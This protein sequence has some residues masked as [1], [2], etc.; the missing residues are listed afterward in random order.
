MNEPA[1]ESN[2][3]N[4]QVSIDDDAWLDYS[5]LAITKMEPMD[6]ASLEL[7]E[8]NLPITLDPDRER[9]IE[10]SS[11]QINDYVS[12]PQSGTSSSLPSNPAPSSFHNETHAM[13]N[14]QNS[15]RTETFDHHIATK[16]AEMSSNQSITGSKLPA[17]KALPP[18]SSKALDHISRPQ[19]ECYTVSSPCFSKKQPTSNIIEPDKYFLAPSSPLSPS[20]HPS[21]KQPWSAPPPLQIPDAKLFNSKDPVPSPMPRSIPIPPLSLSTYLQLELS[22]HKPSPLYIHRSRMSDVPY[23]SSSVKMERLQNFL[24]LP[25]QLEQVLWF[26]AIACLDAWLFTFTI[27]PLRFLKALLI[28]SHSWGRNAANE[29]HLVAEYIYAGAGRMWK[30]QRRRSA[31]ERSAYNLSTKI[32]PRLIVPARNELPLPTLQMPSSAQRENASPAHSHP[33]QDGK[34]RSSNAHKHRKSKSM[35]STLLPDHKADI[36]KGFL[37]IISCM[38]LMHFDASRM[39]HNIRGQAAIKLYVIYNVLEVNICIPL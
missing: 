20:S 39:Y 33:Q 25:P 36:I 21:P 29:V 30:R 22:S 13:W 19:S 3:I 27:L 38:I 34:R 15:S 4:G 2:E 32:D 18:L 11:S 37:I 16:N 7:R 26:G 6:E 9:A 5:H 31:I 12:M 24:L 14:E 23:E 28:L 8:R 17:K 10:L 35:P 1:I